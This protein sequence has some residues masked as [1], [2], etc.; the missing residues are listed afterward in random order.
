M[1]IISPD[2]KARCFWEGYLTWKI[3]P[4]SKSLITMVGCCPLRMG[5]NGHAWLVNG[6]DPITTYKS[7]DDPPSSRGDWIVKPNL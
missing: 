3:I 2:H 1:V 6:G 5:L 7:R 4:V